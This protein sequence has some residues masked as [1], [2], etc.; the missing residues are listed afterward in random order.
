M[1]EAAEVKEIKSEILTKMGKN[2]IE[3]RRTAIKKFQPSGNE[4]SFIR[5][6]LHCFKFDLI[7]FIILMEKRFNK[8]AL[9][10]TAQHLWLSF[11]QFHQHFKISFTVNFFASKKHKKLRI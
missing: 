4:L 6:L 7:L 3:F 2:G 10:K 1:V 11:S 9:I 8:L 5:L